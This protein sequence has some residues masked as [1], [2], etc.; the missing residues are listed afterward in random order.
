M[1]SLGYIN[2]ARQLDS[3]VRSEVNVRFSGP[4]KIIPKL[5][6]RGYDAKDISAS[7]SRLLDAGEIDFSIARARLIES[8]GIDPEDSEGVKKI[9]YRNGHSIC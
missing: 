2:T 9:L 3:L 6:S 4:A 1:V 8:K 5:K 7:I